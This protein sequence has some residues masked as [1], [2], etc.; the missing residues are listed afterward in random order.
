MQHGERGDRGL[1]PARRAQQVAGHRF[2]GGEHELAGVLAEHGLDR[3]RLDAIAGRRRRTVRVDVV[4][5]RRGRPGVG[6]RCAHRADRAVA[7]DRRRGHVVRIARQAVAGD[8]GIDPCS[9]GQ[10]VLALLEQADPRALTHHEAVAVGVER[11]ARVRRIVVA[12]GQR[13]HRAES[14]DGERRDH[15][16]RSPGDHQVSVAF[17]DQAHRLADRVGSGGA[18]RGQRQ[19]RSLGPHED[20][21]VARGHVQD[22]TGDEERRDTPGTAL[23]QLAV[24][25]LEQR[26][27]ADARADVH[28]NALGVAGVDR[29]ARVAQRLARRRDRVV[30]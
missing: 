14:T 22:H 24:H 18:R 4:D 27:P 6:Q 3:H 29:E 1:E 19:V 7:V 5:L 15:G 26:E 23:E 25:L 10:R 21:H 9:A 13:L 16:L 17:A 8:L 28:A 2:R 12:R 11:A 20:R 30:R